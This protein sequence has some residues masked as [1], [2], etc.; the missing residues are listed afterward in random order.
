MAKEK[1]K[2][3][4]ESLKYDK[5]DLNT[6]DRLLKVLGYFAGSLLM[7]VLYILVFSHLFGTPSERKLRRE[8]RQLQSQYEMLN[9]KM[10]QMKAVLADL[11]ERD[12]N[13]YR[14]VFEAEPISSAVRIQGVGGVD[15]YNEL[16]G[17]DNSDLVIE[18]SEQLD[19]LSKRIYVQSKS[20][21]D[22]INMAMNKEAMVSSIPAIQPISNKDLKRTASGW[23][24]RIHPIYK[25]RKFHYGMDFTAPTGT[26][27]YATGDGKVVETSRSRRGYG[28]KMVIDHGYGYKT[29]Y[30]H[31]NKFNVKRGQK[32]KRGDVIAFVGNT[33]VSTAPHLHYEVRQNG[34]LVN[35]LNFY[36]ND[37]TGD[38]YERMIE[39]SLNS[40][41]SFD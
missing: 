37:L 35:P 4:P 9:E 16:E 8:N 10:N 17:F 34:K 1:F 2:F 40:G 29:L 13:L 24:W 31:L 27:V 32:V 26:E 22:L 36:F 6:S 39:I 3:N 18:T 23:G 21:D 19:A 5:V 28:N 25:I 20:Y 15:R 7:A 30:G 41:Q 11:E 14:T 38:E 12:D 33:G